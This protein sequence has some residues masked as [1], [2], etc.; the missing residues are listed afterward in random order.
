MGTWGAGLFD[1]DVASD[2]RGEFES[3]L[4]AGMAPSAA[5]HAAL[6]AL[7]EEAADPDDGPVVYL[8][9]AS[10][11]LDLGVSRHPAV[12]RAAQIVREGE[13]LERWR[14][15]GPEALAERE[16][17]YAELAARLP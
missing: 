11:L 1:D 6:Q 2:T 10:L 5:A 12:A 7:S 13:G 4:E 17:V 16:A 9:L 8:A 3:C 14:D 15:A